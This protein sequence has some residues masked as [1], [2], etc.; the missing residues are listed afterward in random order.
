MAEADTSSGRFWDILGKIA[1][2]FGIVPVFVAWWYGETFAAKLFA[3]YITM[4]N[5]TLILH[6]AYLHRE[7]RYR[8]AAAVTYIHGINHK[9]R[10]YTTALSL[11]L[12]STGLE[13]SDLTEPY[14][15]QMHV[16]LDQVAAAFTEITGKRCS[17]CV[18]ELRSDLTLKTISRDTQSI[19]ERP[20]HQPP[21]P[22]NK[23]TPCLEV[24]YQPKK[25]VRYYICRH[26]PRAWRN[27]KFKSASIDP[28]DKPPAV[29]KIWFLYYC[30]YWP[31]KFK[32]CL[33]VPIRYVALK[34]GSS[35]NSAHCWGFL[36]IDSEE[37]RVFRHEHWRM[38]A[39]FADILYVYSFQIDAILNS[40]TIKAAPQK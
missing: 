27:K 5:L 21:H 35:K 17:A 36:C 39:A 29:R 24:F 30:K 12:K 2:I 14:G 34:E 13:N 40:G 26:V 3:I 9:I 33:V 7:G 1:T 10:D 32:S 38:A 37:T 16:L 20:I 4:L 22:L 8:Y 23:D 19:N 25:F 31:L 11:K 15:I 18:K 6:V 28:N